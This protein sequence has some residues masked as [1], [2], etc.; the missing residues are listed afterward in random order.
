M[1]L[2]GTDM[3]MSMGMEMD[4]PDV[5]KLERSRRNARE[6]R[7]R[8]KEYIGSLE[9]QVSMMENRDTQLQGQLDAARIQLAMLQAK[10]GD[11]IRHRA[12]SSGPGL[13]IEV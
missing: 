9:A 13:T 1:V 6:C 4:D 7:V 12:G 3:G 10:H 2:S 5:S 11:L 8:K